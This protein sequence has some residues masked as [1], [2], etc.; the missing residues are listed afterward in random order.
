MSV[1]YKAQIVVGYELTA[2]WNEIVDEEFFEE[3]IDNFLTTSVYRDDF[4]L[5]G[6]IVEEVDEG[7]FVEFNHDLLLTEIALLRKFANKYPKAIANPNQ[8]RSQYLICKVW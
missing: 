1:N 2:N 4:F 7:H 5:F 6:V 8:F 3:Y